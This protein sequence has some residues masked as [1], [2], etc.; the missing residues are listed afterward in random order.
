MVET[1]P[2]EE[3]LQMRYE[4]GVFWFVRGTPE[5]LAVSI[6]GVD[7]RSREV[8]HEFASPYQDVGHFVVDRDSIWITDYK[9]PE[10]TRI[11]I[12]SGL[13]TDRIPIGGGPP[14][15]FRGTSTGGEQIAVAGGSVWV[16]RTGEVVRVDPERGRRR[17]SLSH[18]LRVGHDGRERAGV[19]L[20][21]GRCRLDRRNY[22]RGRP[23]RRY[24]PPAERDPCGRTGLGC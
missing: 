11:D 9:T 2:F 17:R 18:A 13:V 12:A 14:R 15:Q 19:D 5:F 3:V 4:A 10:L 20:Q 21:T 7:E 16:G 1:L 24:R 8:I 22:G 6:V 23:G